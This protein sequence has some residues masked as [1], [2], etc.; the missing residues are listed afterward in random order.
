MQLLGELLE[1]RDAKDEVLR[2]A[3]RVDAGEWG[4]GWHYSRDSAGNLY[5]FDDSLIEEFD[6]ILLKEREILR[7]ADASAF[8]LLD[9]Y[10]FNYSVYAEVIEH[11]GI[12]MQDWVNPGREFD[13]MLIE[14]R[15]KG[16]REAH[17]SMNADCECC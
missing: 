9:R 8:G 3:E 2:T 13:A 14:F 6:N 17:R 16:I 7:N 15:E 10:A 4:D 1:L 11:F 12:K 5:R